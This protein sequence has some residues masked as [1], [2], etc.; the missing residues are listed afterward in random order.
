[1]AKEQYVIVRVDRDPFDTHAALTLGEAVELAMPDAG[2]V[3]EWTVWMANDAGL[4]RLTC[5]SSWG[6]LEWNHNQTMLRTSC[7]GQWVTV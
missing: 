4:A 2:S 7:G 6:M 3:V 5:R 1:M